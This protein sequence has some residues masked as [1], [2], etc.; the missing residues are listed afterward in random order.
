MQVYLI[1]YCATPISLLD[2]YR[3]G[4]IA[5]GRQNTRLQGLQEAQ[6]VSRLQQELE[7]DGIR[8]PVRE[9][10]GSILGREKSPD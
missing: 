5:S 1:C 2:T 9:G 6:G 7:V 3:N 4:V 10:R 8:A